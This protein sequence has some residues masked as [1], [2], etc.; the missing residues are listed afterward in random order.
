MNRFEYAGKTNVRPT[1]M[2]LAAGWLLATFL[3]AGECMAGDGGGVAIIVHKDSPIAS[4]TVDDLRRYYSD[5]FL[6]WDSG[7]KVKIFDLPMDDP[8]RQVFSSKV[9]GKAPQDVTM[10]WAN[11]R[12]TNTAKN[13]PTILKSQLLM[14]SKVAHDINALGYVSGAKVEEEKVK[15]VLRIK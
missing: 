6:T 9:L 1:L 15:I 7:E 10:E 12:I 8:T 14:V 4:M 5:V 3:F 13:P 2:A 11:K